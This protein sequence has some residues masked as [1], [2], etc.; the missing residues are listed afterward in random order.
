MKVPIG[1][2][3]AVDCANEI[4]FYQKSTTP[5]E[6]KRLVNCFLSH[7]RRIGAHAGLFAPSDEDLA[8]GIRLF[9]GERLHTHLGPRNVL[10]A[11]TV[12]ACLLLGLQA[13][14]IN[15]NLKQARLKLSGSC[16][17]AQYCVLGE[18]AHSAVGFMRLL[19]SDSDHDAMQ[20]LSH[21]IKVL[22]S[23]RNGKGGWKRFPYY[24]TLLALSEINLTAA[25]EELRYAVPMFEKS[26]KRQ[27]LLEPKFIRRRQQLLKNVLAK[28]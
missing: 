2:A 3:S 1:L 12:R 5:Q 11:E 8:A 21:H 25:V 26:I 28:I 23:L 15:G 4:I 13:S 9:T 20:R 24:Y 14:P 16:F 10:S 27:S 18:C 17:A 6:K 22:S 19:A 7:Q